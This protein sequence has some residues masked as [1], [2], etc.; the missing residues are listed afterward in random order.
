MPNPNL[1]KFIKEAKARGFDDFQIREPLIKKGWPA[2]EVEEAF[3]SLKPNKNKKDEKFKFKNKVNLFLSTD[4][5]KVIEKRAK[6]NLFTISEQ[7]ED[8]L[9]RS[10]VRVKNDRQNREKL[11]DMLVSFFSRKQAY[12][13]IIKLFPV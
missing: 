12:K 8:I 10:C 5:L 2:K 11:D 1:L 4:I 7:I 6:R 3:L 13:H 9:R